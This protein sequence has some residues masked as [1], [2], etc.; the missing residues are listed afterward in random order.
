VVSGTTTSAPA[1]TLV[2]TFAG[3]TRSE[4]RF[5]K[6]VVPKAAS[7]ATD[8]KGRGNMR[9]KAARSGLCLF[10]VVAA[11]VLSSTPASADAGRTN[12]SGRPNGAQVALATPFERCASRLTP[13][14]SE[15]LRMDGGRAKNYPE[16]DSG[17]NRLF[18]GD[19]VL[20]DANDW[21]TVQIDI[22]WP[23]DPSADQFTP[24]GI[25]PVQA[26]PIG[27]PGPGLNKYGLVGWF[28][29]GGIPPWFYGSLPWCVTIPSTVSDA[30]LTL[31]IND[32]VTW[33][34]SGSWHVLINHYW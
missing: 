17:W 29:K 16:H 24:K 12:R 15:Y 23:A 22:G 11:S 32:N 2:N 21:N 26:A 33:D 25:S 28:T 18:P 7:P 13:N 4:R 8:V 1:A 31:S 14:Y 27:W 34:N 3:A 19:V 5:P 20:I 10:I 9:G 30:F 6:L